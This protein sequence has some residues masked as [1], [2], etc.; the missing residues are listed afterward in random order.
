M[1]KIY[2][3]FLVVVL[4]AIVVASLIYGGFFSKLENQKEVEEKIEEV[5][6]LEMLIN[7]SSTE[8]A[9][10]VAV[11]GSNSSGIAHR[12]L[13]DGK[14][15]HVVVADMPDPKEDHSYEGWLVQSDPFN[16]FSTGVMEK[17]E[18]NQWVL[19]YSADEEFENHTRV[20]I[21]E[22]TI[23]DETPEDHIIEGDF[24]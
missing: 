17:N 20:V 10:L 11:D 18:N 5:G 2:S 8:T 13:K 16:F 24:K 19:I 22:E 23:V 7:D 15:Y 3:I 1:S 9:P 6:I 14:L 4:I 12:L 21:T